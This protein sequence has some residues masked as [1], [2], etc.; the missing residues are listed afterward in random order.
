MVNVNGLKNGYD[1]DWYGFSEIKNKV[2]EI[3]GI[4]NWSKIFL[5]VYKLA[6]CVVCVAS[7][8]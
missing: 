2:Y 4:Q 7:D 6:L 3:M 1:T 5:K 8:A